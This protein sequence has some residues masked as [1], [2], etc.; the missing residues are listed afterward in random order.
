M[1]SNGKGGF[2][3]VFSARVK[4]KVEHGKTIK[5]FVA[6]KR[7]PSTSAREEMNNNCEVAC[8]LELRHAN[9]VEIKSVYQL[10]NELWIIMEFMEGG[11][12]AQAI[13]LHALAPSHINFI[14]AQ[15]LRGLEYIHQRGF[16]HRDLKS[17]NIML[18]IEGG[19][20]IIDFGLCANISDGPR[21]QTL[22]T[23]H[24]M[25]PE[26]IMRHPHTTKIDIWSFGIVFLEMYLRCVPF[27]GS[28][29][30][31]MF[32][33]VKGETL[34]YIHLHKFNIPHK[35]YHFVECCL[36]PDPN[37][38]LSATELLQ[39]PIMKKSAPDEDLR[40]LLK[41]IFVSITLHR[42]GI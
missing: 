29:I 12:L 37:K 14:S 39:D 9:I 11:T 13:R 28:R 1:E 30:L 26:M 25:A 7:V 2:G 20:K 35:A 17:N 41:T 34:E 38:R 21:I 19:V 32:K 3:R 8:L 18:S 5:E 27:S 31:S 40:T 6:I 15:I 33:A 42:S 36:Q 24:W 10:P 4:T 16:V 23:S 22:G